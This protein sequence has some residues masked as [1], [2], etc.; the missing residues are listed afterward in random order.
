MAN[1]GAKSFR[2]KH[3]DQARKALNLNF[4]L[5]VPRHIGGRQV[6]EH[7]FEVK[8][9]EAEGRANVV[10]VFG[11]KTIAVHAGIDREVGLAGSSRIAQE[12]VECH[13]GTNVRNSRSQLEFDKVGEVSRSAG[14]KYQNRQVHAV[15]AKQ[16]AFANVGDAQVVST[17]ELGGKGAGEASVAVRVRLYWQKDLRIGRNLAPDKLNVVAECV[18]IDFNPVRARNFI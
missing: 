7:A 16:H 4:G 10:K 2:F 9:L 8:V 11:V 15:L 18:Q 13:G 3:I 17:A 1:L 14:A 12:L 6:R 5:R